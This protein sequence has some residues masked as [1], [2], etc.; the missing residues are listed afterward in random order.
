MHDDLIGEYET[1]QNAKDM[2]DQVKFDFGGTSTTRLR[3]LVLKFE[4]YRKDPKYTMTEHLRMMSG[5]IRD[6]KA[7]GNVLTDEQQVQAVIRSLPDSWISMKQIMTHNEN[8]KNFADISRHVELEAERQEATKSAALIAHGGQR[9]PNGFKHKDKGKAARQGGPSTNAPKVNKGANQHKRKRGAKKNISKMKCYNCNKL[10]HFARD[11]TEPKKVSLSLDLSSIYVC[12]PS[13]IFVCSH[14]FVAK[15]ISDW[16]IDTG[17]TRHVARDRAG[18]VDYRKIPAG[19]HVVYMGNGSYEEALGVDSYQ[20]HL[21]T[22]RTLLLHDVLYVPGVLYNLLSV[23]TLLQLGYDFHLSWNGLD[24][25]LDDV[26][27]GHGSSTWHARLGHIGKDRMTRLAREGLLGP[28]A[29]VDLPICEP[30]LAGKACRKPFGKAVRAT[31][32]LELIHSDICGPMN[33]KARHG[34]SY[35]LTFIDDY[36]R[37]GYVQ[38]IAH[39][40]E[41]LDCFKR[42]VA[43]DLCEENGIRKQLTISNTPQQNGVAERRNRTLLDMVRSMMAQANLP[44]SF[45][46][47]ALLTAAYIL[48]R[49]PSHTAHK[50]GKLGPRARKHI[51]IRYSDSS[52]GY[53]MYGEHPNGGMTEIESRDIDFIETDFPSIGDANKDLDLYELEEDEGTLPSSSEGGG[54]VPRPVIAEDSGSDLQPS[55]SI[56]L[57]QDSQARRVSNRGHIPR[58]HF[59]IEGN[60]LLCNAKHVDEPASFSE[61]LH[62][63]D[64]DEWMTAMQEEMSS[65]DKNNVWELVD[66]PPG[67]KT[68]GNKWVLKVKRKADGSI[69]RYKARLVAKGYT[70][71]EGIDY[72]D[73]FSPMM[74][75]SI[76]LNQRVL[77]SRDMSA[78]CVDSNVP[79]MVSNSHL[80]NGI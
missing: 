1:F 12:Y 23:F 69:D 34:A 40:Y 10:G 74:K 18:F 27:F 56:T 5:M 30:C 54:L 65:M 60:V 22:G 72:E 75:R 42:F 26:I 17:A 49:V 36:T 70:Q 4:E 47:D 9:K 61:A 50:Y 67:R 71:R 11:C 68:I 66:L 25:L 8:I 35:F 76:W 80:S 52:K 20:L 15:S 37:Y 59:E 24:I 21:R 62:S 57:D 63:P 79:S 29:K 73:T 14:V 7:A 78:K 53:V 44:I 28:L 13:S 3:S 46:G 16:I 58:R 51:F 19:T 77:K 45:W 64:R 2:W 32:P 43:E 33:V 31:Q 41:A 55:G 39:R 38:L 48:N 6:L